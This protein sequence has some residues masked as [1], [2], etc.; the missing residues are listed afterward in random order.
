VLVLASGLAFAVVAGPGQRVTLPAAS[1]F[2]LPAGL[3]R[4]LAVGALYVSALGGVLAFTVAASEDAGLSETEAGIVLACLNIGAGAGR[5]IWGRI[6][7]GAGGTR[8]VR[9][10]VELGIFGT[11]AALAFPVLVHLGPVTAVVAALALAFGALGFNGLVY[12][13]A[14]ELGGRLHAGAA[15]GVASTVVFTVGAVVGPVYGVLVEQAGYDAM[16]VVVAAV[17]LA[18]AVVARGLHG[19]V[20]AAHAAA[21]PDAGVVSGR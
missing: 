19:A 18:G 14:G 17:M 21:A 3:P 5:V 6:A 1:R 8:R 13:I 9:T 11:V 7:D 2:A 15:V 10:L 16:F 12:L 4:L 20:G